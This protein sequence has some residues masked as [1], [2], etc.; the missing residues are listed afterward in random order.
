[1]AGKVK[2]KKKMERHTTSKT[3][4]KKP[5]GTIFKGQA[6]QSMLSNIQEERRTHS[7]RGGRIKITQSRLDFIKQSWKSI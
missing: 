2:G 1:M 7:H 3:Q 6:G 4:T 5:F